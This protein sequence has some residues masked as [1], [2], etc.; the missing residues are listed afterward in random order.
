MVVGDLY[1]RDWFITEGLKAGDQVV[2]NGGLT[3]RPDIPVTIKAPEAQ[4][5]AGASQVTEQKPAPAA[6]GH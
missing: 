5:P 2:V 6:K 4:K 1:G 3:L